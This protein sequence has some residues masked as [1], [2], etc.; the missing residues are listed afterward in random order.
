[1]SSSISLMFLILSSSRADSECSL[2]RERREGSEVMNLSFCL[3][4][5]SPWRVNATTHSSSPASSF[6]VAPAAS[7]GRLSVDAPRVTGV[8]VAPA[9]PDAS[10]VVVMTGEERRGVP[11][12]G[13]AARWVGASCSRQYWRKRSAESSQ[14]CGGARVR[15][16]VSRARAG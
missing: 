12:W 8:I 14:N 7:F 3:G 1:M 16:R 2:I 6:S 10:R 11:D 9:A 13:L 5:R 4:V 15:L